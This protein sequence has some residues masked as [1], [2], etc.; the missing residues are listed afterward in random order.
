MFEKKSVEMSGQRKDLRK[1]PRAT[2]SRF[3]SI[4][5]CLTI[6]REKKFLPL[7][8]KKKKKP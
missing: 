1:T 8:K 2:G 7:K 5:L 4:K 3:S 6:L